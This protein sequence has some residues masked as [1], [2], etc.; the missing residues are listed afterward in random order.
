MHMSDAAMD[1]PPAGD[2]PVTFKKTVK[3]WGIGAHGEQANFT[4]L[5]L[6]CNEADFCNQTLDGTNPGL[7]QVPPGSA[8][9]VCLFWPAAALSPRPL[10]GTRKYVPTNSET[11]FF[12]RVGVPDLRC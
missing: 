5:V 7:V 2:A 4:V 8:R 9:L 3:T 6:R 12:M 1:S 10:S 11:A